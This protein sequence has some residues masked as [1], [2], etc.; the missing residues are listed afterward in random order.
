MMVLEEGGRGETVG[1][2]LG[3]VIL[4][5]PILYACCKKLFLTLN[6]FLESKIRR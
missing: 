6:I 5:G 1:G 4:C 3:A 2:G